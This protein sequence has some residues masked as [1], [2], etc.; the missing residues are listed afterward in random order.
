MYKSSVD[1]QIDKDVADYYQKLVD[2]GMDEE[3]A[4]EK[5]DDYYNYLQGQYSEHSSG[6]YK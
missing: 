5:S 1:R 2:G 4:Q 6:L 3:E